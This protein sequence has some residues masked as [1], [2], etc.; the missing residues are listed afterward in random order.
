MH[1]LDLVSHLSSDDI[2]D[3]LKED[4][5]SASGSIADKILD[6]VLDLIADSIT[7]SIS[8]LVVDSMFVLI[9]C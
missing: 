4:L 8:D 1:L 6:L 7:D 2:V 5:V 3:I 9:N